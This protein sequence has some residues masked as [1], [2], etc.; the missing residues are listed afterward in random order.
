MF[1]SL[2]SNISD[3]CHKQPA[4]SSASRFTAQA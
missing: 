1:A 4:I 2:G 3:L